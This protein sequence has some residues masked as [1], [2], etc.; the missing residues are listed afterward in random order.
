ME[1]RVT[2]ERSSWRPCLLSRRRHGFT[3]PEVLVYATILLVLV[4]SIVA[5]VQGGLR[6]MRQGADYQEAQQQTLLG[7]K[8]I[9]AD[10]SKSTTARRDPDPG[11]FPAPPPPPPNPPLPDPTL[12]YFICLSPVPDPPAVDWTYSGDQLEYHAWICYYIDESTGLPGSLIRVRRPLPAPATSNLVG[13]VP[14]LTDFQSP[15]AGDV[16]KVI[17]RGVSYLYF[18]D[19][20]TGQQV[21]FMLGC[22]TNWEDT[23]GDRINDRQIVTT[24]YG[25]SLATMPNP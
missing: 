24:I 12:R 17:S 20:A 6:Y 8:A 10:L 22:S 2:R 23:G 21:F 19:G 14:P 11:L 3:L 5:A 1:F 15:V 16:R 4:G 7:I 18:D 25:Q 13:V 9:T